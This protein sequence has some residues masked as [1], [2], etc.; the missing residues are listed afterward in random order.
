MQKTA[1]ANGAPTDN[2]VPAKT[3]AAQLTQSPKITETPSVGQATP[4]AISRCDKIVFTHTV[5]DEQG[6]SGLWLKISGDLNGDGLPDLIVG[7]NA[8]GGLIWY[9][10]PTWTKH[11]ISEEGNFSTDGAVVDVD[12]DGDLD[13]V[14]LAAYELRWYENPSWEMYPISAEVLH[15]VEAADFDRDGDIDLVARNQ[16]EWGMDGD[17]L[18]FYRQETPLDWT[19]RAVPIA[20]GEGLAAADI[21]RDGDAD[22]I[23]NGSWY[24]NDND[25]LDGA[26]RETRYSANW[27]TPEYV[28]SQ[29]R[30][31]WGWKPGYR[32]GALGIGR[33][34]LPDKLVQSASRPKN[35]RIGR[36]LSS[37]KM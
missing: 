9:E 7:G 27:T 2:Q 8:S 30:Y 31:R 16:G 5:V 34:Q 26:W 28:C 18:H 10:F 15:D 21:D 12:N 25:I 1:P 23:V 37:K 35:K 6:P 13:L 33:G 17:Q 3:A 24:E 14:V 22:I 4:S 36:K 11:T 20:N 32:A 29:R 19:H